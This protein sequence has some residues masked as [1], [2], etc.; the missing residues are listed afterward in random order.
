MKKTGCLH[1]TDL[2]LHYY[3]ELP[4]DGEQARHLRDCPGCA[5][6]MTSLRNDLARLPSLADEVDH[7]AGTRM[8]ARVSEQLRARRSYRWPLLG[9]AAVATVAL[10]VTLAGGP[11]APEAPHTARLTPANGALLDLNEALPE[12]DFLEDL[13]LLKEL[14]LLSRIEGV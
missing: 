11:P 3:G 1:E 7:S 13:E 4:A 8:A 12:I 9:G 5:L 14:D 6:Q 10:V 2:I